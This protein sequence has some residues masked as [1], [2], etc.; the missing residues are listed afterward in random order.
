MTQDDIFNKVKAVLVDALAAD[1]DDVTPQASLV[2][3]LG[4]E[5]IDFLDIVFKLEQAFGFKIAQG[6]LFPENVAQDPRYVK[7]GMVTP[8][9][10]TAL[11]ARLPHVNFDRFAAEP[12]L[13]KVAEVFTVDTLVKFVE[14]KLAAK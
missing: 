11:R 10:L 1:E 13:S 9:G 3:D 2:K 8:E 7:D 12:K 6:E 5:S 4:A 14:K